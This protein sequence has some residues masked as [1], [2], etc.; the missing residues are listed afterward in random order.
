M[1]A[2]SLTGKH[3]VLG[4]TGGIAAYKTPELVRQLRALGATVQI[5]CTPNA[6]RFVAPLT[7]QA[8]SGQP[9]FCDPWEPSALD[10]MQHIALA[11][12]ATA[13]LIA[14][15]TANCIAK[16]AAGMADDLLLNLC[17]ATKAP[18]FIVPA[19]NQQMWSSPFTQSNIATLITNGMTVLPVAEG[20]QACGD[21]GPG[22]MLE[23]ETIVTFLTEAM[24]KRAQP[25]QGKRVLFTAGPTQE[26]VDPVRYITNHSSGKMGYALAIAAHRLGADVT[27]VSGPVQ[28]SRHPNIHYIPV[29]SANEMAAAV[30]HLQGQVDVFIAVA[31]V[32]DYRVDNQFPQ[33]ISRSAHTLTLQLVKNP[34]ILASVTQ[35]QP[36]P[37]CVGFAAQTHELQ[38][39]AQ[40]KLQCKSLDMIVANLVG[41]PECG[42]GSDENAALVLWDNQ[43]REYPKQSKVVLAQSLMQLITE[44]YYEQKVHS[45]KNS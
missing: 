29:V 5:V 38:K 2:L 44:V 20:E 6:V 37:F 35:W 16:L 19:M 28:L 32:S 21:V 25:L 10:G 24:C 8:V 42:F 4:I 27:V 13:V 3:M 39:C 22:R 15:A 30:A 11:R 17:L 33:K 40:E 14:P 9:V 34:D 23:P 26:A 41:T 36:K 7:L 1:V 12:A 31:A 43:Q 18:I 45:N